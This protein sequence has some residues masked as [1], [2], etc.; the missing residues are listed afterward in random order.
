M[1]RIRA[2]RTCSPAPAHPRQARLTHQPSHPLAARPAPAGRQLGVDP[3]H[4]VGASR[5]LVDGANRAA[6]LLV[7][8]HTRRAPTAPPRV[9]PAG[10]DTQHQAS[11][12]SERHFRGT[13]STPHAWPGSPSRARRPPGHRTGLPSKPDR[14]FFLRSRAPREADNSPDEADAAPQAQSSSIRHHDV[15]HRD[16]S[17]VPS[18][19]WSGHNTRTL[20]PVPLPNGPTGPARPSV[21]GTPAHTADESL[22][23]RTPPLH[24]LKV[25]TDPTFADAILDRLVHNAYKLKLKGDSMRKTKTPLTQADH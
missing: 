4:P 18:Y 14:G 3:R 23:L 7:A 15:L 13:S 25:S 11:S 5:F 22:P 9:V 6:Q 17:D 10:G 16:H 21:A 12:R 1:G 20:G 2:C 24:S 8:L 19:G